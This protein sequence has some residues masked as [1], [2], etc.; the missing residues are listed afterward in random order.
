MP[1]SGAGRPRTRPDRVRTDKA[2][3]SQ[4]NHA[5]LRRRGIG[6]TIPPKADQIRHR[7]NRGARGGRPPEFGAIDY[8]RHH[9]VEVARGLLSFRGDEDAE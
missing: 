5:C 9:A 6:C 3:R 1:L 8:L 2:Y 7:K 4:A